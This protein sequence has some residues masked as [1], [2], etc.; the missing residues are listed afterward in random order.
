MV[1]GHGNINSACS[2]RNELWNR[3]HFHAPGKIS[4]AA[5]ASN[6]TELETALCTHVSLLFRNATTRNAMSGGDSVA[7]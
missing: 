3:R 2:P 6:V 7:C 4:S 5:T 1:G